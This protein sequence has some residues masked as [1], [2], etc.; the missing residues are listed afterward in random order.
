MAGLRVYIESLGCPKITVDSEYMVGILKHEG[1]KI[2]KDPEMADAILVNTCGFIEPAKEESIDTI[3][4]FAELKRSGLK[5]LIVCGCLYERYKSEL[6]RELPEVD[7]FLGVNEL[8]KIT[9][10]LL[11]KSTGYN[12]VYKF[13]EIIGKPHIGYLKIAD[14]CSNRCTFCSIP[15]IKG[16]FK[17]RERDDLV[18][19]A[20]ILAEKGVKELYIVAQDTT[21]YMFERGERNQLVRLLEKLEEIDGIEW[22][23]VM[24][25]YPTFITDDLIDFLST[26]KK[27]VRYLDIPFQHASD[28]VLK[29]M[30]RMYFRN[31]IENLIEKL[32]TKVKDISIRSTFIVGFPTET[33]EDFGEL[34]DFIEQA[35][36]DWMGFFKYYHEDGTI[37]HRLYSDIED[38]VKQERIEEIEDVASSVSEEKN[39]GFVGKRQDVMI[40]GRAEDISGYCVARSFRSAYEIDGIVYVEGTTFREGQMISVEIKDSIN[41]FDLKAVSMSINV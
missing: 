15:A 22:I 8:T 38:Q 17:S 41:P 12:N 28:K 6:E 35:R 24:Y 18:I 26:S 13:R 1:C 14:G 34:V 32:R 10:I 11:N 23:R 4:G 21:A 9:D 33:K 39:L 16:G 31:D 40:D 3:L 7:N 30:G 36:L 19:E 27:V 29:D 37:S 25:T 2:V 5:K 20:R